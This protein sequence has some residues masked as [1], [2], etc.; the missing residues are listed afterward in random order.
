MSV[1]F[2][3]RISLP[4]GGLV[5]T[6]EYTWTF[7]QYYKFNECANIWQTK[8]SCDNSFEQKSS[9]L[10]FRSKIFFAFTVNEERTLIKSSMQRNAFAD[11]VL[12]LQTTLTLKCMRCYE[13]IEDHTF[14]KTSKC[15]N[16]IE[17]EKEMI[18]QL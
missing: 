9:L 11:F 10:S 2:Q 7:F 3:N 12:K 6:A 18:V 14:A 15:S 5:S 8:C 16:C 17:S 1:W 4:S 13:G